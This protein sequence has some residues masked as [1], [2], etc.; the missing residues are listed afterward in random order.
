M[1]YGFAM[2]V[3]GILLCFGSSA[4]PFVCAP[5]TVPVCSSPIVAVAPCCEPSALF[6]PAPPVVAPIIAPPV[7]PLCAS[8]AAPFPDPAL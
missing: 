7:V 5:P 4:Y 6:P 2:V 1:R 8:P 3:L